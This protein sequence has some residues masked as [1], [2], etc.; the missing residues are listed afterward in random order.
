MKMMTAPA[1][2]PITVSVPPTIQPNRKPPRM[3]SS[4]APG[5]DRATAT[6]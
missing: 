4:D 6:M 5:N 2:A 3:V 1:V